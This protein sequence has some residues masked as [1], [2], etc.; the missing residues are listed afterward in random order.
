MSACQHGVTMSR[1]QDVSGEGWLDEWMNGWMS[2]CQDVSILCHHISYSLV[3]GTWMKSTMRKTLIKEKRM[4]PKLIDTLGTLLTIR[5][6]IA[7]FDT[8]MGKLKD[9]LFVIETNR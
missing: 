5:T 1:C 2:T 4:T 6:E 8:I 3:N 7:S 9:A